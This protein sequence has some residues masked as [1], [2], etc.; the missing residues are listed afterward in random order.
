MLEFD[1]FNRLAGKHRCKVHGSTWADRHK[2]RTRSTIDGSGGPG[3]DTS[4]VSKRFIERLFKE[5]C[6]CPVCKATFATDAQYYAHLKQKKEMD[7]AHA[8]FFESNAGI[9]DELSG[10]LNPGE[11][12][13]CEPVKTS[14]APETVPGFS[15]T[16]L[17]ENRFGRIHIKQKGKEAKPVHDARDWAGDFLKDNPNG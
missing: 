11:I 17:S 10:G 9:I 5:S 13:T 14:L 3:F 8:Q 15:S 7:D 12:E 16:E 6:Q 4:A 2:V 1:K